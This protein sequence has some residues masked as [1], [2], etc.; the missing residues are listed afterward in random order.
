VCVDRI[1][2]RASRRVEEEDVV[3]RLRIVVGN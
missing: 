3:G 1:D 2:D